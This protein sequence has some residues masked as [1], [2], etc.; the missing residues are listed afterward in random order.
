MTLSGPTAAGPG[1]YT[2]LARSVTV[3]QKFCVAY[4]VPFGATATPTPSRRQ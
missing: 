2:T 3:Q 4:T 1:W